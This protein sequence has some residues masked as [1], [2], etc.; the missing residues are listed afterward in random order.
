MWFQ[1]VTGADKLER[2]RLLRFGLE[3]I[4]YETLKGRTNEDG[5]EGDEVPIL[6]P[7]TYKAVKGL[8]RLLPT[9]HDEFSY[10]FQVVKQIA[11]SV[12][13]EENPDKSDP[14]SRAQKPL[15]C[16]Q[17]RVE[18]DTWYSLGKCLLNAFSKL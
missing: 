3:S 18:A 17:L 8:M 2:K 5:F 12:G 7:M 13:I 15:E 11:R 16:E 1:V 9:V 14:E 6:P 10:D 4:L